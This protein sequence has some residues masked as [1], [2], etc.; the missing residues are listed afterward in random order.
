MQPTHPPPRFC[1]QCGAAL[2]PGNPRFCIECGHAIGGTGRVLRAEA[3]D[4]QRPPPHAARS[5]QHAV[6]LPNAGTAQSV[7]GGTVKLPTSGAVPPGLW[8]APE[9]P[10]AADAVAVYVPLRAVRG[11][12]SGLTSHGWRRVARG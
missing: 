6:H 8:F 10:G 2:P 9:P 7:V 1:T 4:N 12:W 5:T 11:G 3:I